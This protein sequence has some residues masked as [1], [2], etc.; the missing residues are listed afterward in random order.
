MYEKQMNIMGKFKRTIL[1]HSKEGIIVLQVLTDKEEQQ[2]DKSEKEYGELKYLFDKKY[3]I[4]AKNIYLYGD[5][6]LNNKEDIKLI[7]KFKNVICDDLNPA[8]WIYSNINFETGEVT[9][10]EEGIYKGYS[11]TNYM[12]W[13]LYNYLLIGKPKKII[14]YSIPGKVIKDDYKWRI[15]DTKI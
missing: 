8:N 5:L 6:N 3:L 11:T 14:V 13:F 10:N 4:R 15:R 9:S 1:N 7:D 2:I 12:K